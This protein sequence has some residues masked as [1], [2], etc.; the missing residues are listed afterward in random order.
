M[1]T[2]SRVVM[3]MQEKLQ[4]LGTLQKEADAIREEL[5]IS[6]PKAVVYMASFSVVDDEVVVVEADGFGGAQASI[7]EGNYPID[8]VVQYEKQF[9]SEAEAVDAAE[10]LVA[11]RRTPSEILA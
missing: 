10:E 4:R 5:A 2:K 6:A 8:F 7:V 9:S 3:S 11:H 1:R